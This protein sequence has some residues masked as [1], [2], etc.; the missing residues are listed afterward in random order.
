MTTS[1]ADGTMSDELAQF[2]LLKEI[3]DAEHKKP[4]TSGH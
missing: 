2:D 1:L 4:W 3:E